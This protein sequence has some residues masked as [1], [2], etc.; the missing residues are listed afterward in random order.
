MCTTLLLALAALLSSSHCEDVPTPTAGGASKGTD[1]NSVPSIGV[2]DN[3]GS[4]MCCDS[5]RSSM[6]VSVS[7]DE[8][9]LARW[10][11]HALEGMATDVGVSLNLDAD[12]DVDSEEFVDLSGVNG[13]NLKEGKLL[14]CCVA[15]LPKQSIDTSPS[16]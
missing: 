9:S 10:D 2:V 4:E 15:K 6:S 8:E 3:N 5:S 14:F 13:V 11:E 12:L 7:S 1:E 16:H